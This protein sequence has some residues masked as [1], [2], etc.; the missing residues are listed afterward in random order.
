MV[1]L[2]PHV[3]LPL[4]NQSR[5]ISSVDTVKFI[6]TTG[7]NS[8]G[9]GFRPPDLSVVSSQVAALL[10]ELLPVLKL[11][12]ADVASKVMFSSERAIDAISV[13]NYLCKSSKKPVSFSAVRLMLKLAPG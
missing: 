12:S 8:P 3:L 10:P 6:N 4:L 5:N 2:L 7:E 13:L 9:S 11:S 1:D